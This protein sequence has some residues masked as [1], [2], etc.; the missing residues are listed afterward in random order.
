MT[1][2]FIN[3]SIDS[4]STWIGLVLTLIVA[5]F[6]FNFFVRREG[7]YKENYA[8][9]LLITMAL[10]TGQYGHYW[11]VKGAI[12]TFL[13]TMFFFG[14][15]ISTAYHSYLIN[16][17]TNPR[18]NSQIDT[19]EEAMKAGIL[20]QVGENTVDFFR[21]DDSVRRTDECQAHH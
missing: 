3:F 11:P 15:H 2:T 16:V 10:C 7:V 5:S 4:V 19:V 13:A 6:F 8:W 9:S 21:K 1:R 18:F 17:L 12:K 14:I 20:F